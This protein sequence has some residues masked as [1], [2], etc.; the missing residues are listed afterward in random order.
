M[1]IARGW[2]SKRAAKAIK[3]WL[4]EA[5]LL[6]SKPKPTWKDKKKAER[7]EKRA[8]RLKKG[9]LSGKGKQPPHIQTRK[10]AAERMSKKTQ[11]KTPDY[12]REGGGKDRDWWNFTPAEREKFKAMKEKAKHKP[13]RVVDVKKGAQVGV[14]PGV[15]VKNIKKKGRRWREEQ[16]RRLQAQGLSPEG[17]TMKEE[18]LLYS[19]K[20][21]PTEAEKI[22]AIRK[23]H[24]KA[25]QKAKAKAEAEK[26]KRRH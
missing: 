4:K 2:M 26:K 17:M 16:D 25:Y 20:P 7:L 8:D 24:R 9:V 19:L 3:R 13:L 22:K 12:W 11:S 21:N 1:S 10:E 6:K 14:Y 5:K 23:E 15:K 18:R